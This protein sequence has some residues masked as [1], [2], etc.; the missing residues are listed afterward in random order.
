M[1]RSTILTT[2]A[3]GLTPVLLLVSLYV[4]FRGHNAPGG[5]FAGGLVMGTAIILRYLAEGHPGIR[6][7]RLDPVVLIAAGLGLALITST[8]P[9]VFGSQF[10]DSKLID[11]DVPL[12]GEIHFVTAGFFDIGVHVLVVGVVM[13][14]LIAFARA[15]DEAGSTGDSVGAAPAGGGAAT[16]AGDSP[17]TATSTG[18]RP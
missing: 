4:T 1:R 6:S 7:S 17:V 10:M 9:L 3:S 2:T 18:E 13:S 14:I 12:I 16:P 15:D 8:A 11:L 5:G